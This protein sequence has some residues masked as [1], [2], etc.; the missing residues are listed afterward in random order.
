MLYQNQKLTRGICLK[1]ISTE[2]AQSPGRTERLGVVGVDW[3]PTQLLL[4]VLRCG[5][6]N[7][8]VFR[9]KYAHS[10]GSLIRTT[11]LDWLI[12][13]LVL[14]IQLAQQPE[15]KC[16]LPVQ[17][18]VLKRLKHNGTVCPIC[19]DA[20][21]LSTSPLRDKQQSDLMMQGLRQFHAKYQN[22]WNLRYGY[23]YQ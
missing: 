3:L 22:E 19:S 4:K 13:R 16:Q 10:F 7:Q 18:H 21:A 15:C 20:F 11:P 14:S 23:C 17:E 1:Y 9:I 6:L 2:G 5:L 12:F 8:Y